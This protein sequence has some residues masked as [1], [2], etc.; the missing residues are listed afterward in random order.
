MN[1]RT[2]ACLALSAA[3]AAAQPAISPEAS[4]QARVP[5]RVSSEQTVGGFAFPESVAYD[6]RAKVLYVSEFGSKLA[7]AEKD[8]MGRISRVSLNGKVLEQ[9]FLPAA[10]GEPLNKPKGIWVRGARLWVTDIDVVWIFDLK[11]KKG[12]KAA[13]PGIQFANDPAVVGNV[14]Y[15]SD[16]RSDQL[17]KV[18]PAD[19]LNS[20]SEPRVTSVFKGASVSP[21]G[22]YPARDGMLLIVGF[23]APD[24]PRGIFA[25]GVSGQIKDLSGPIGRLDGIYELPGGT[26][27]A[28]DWNSGSLFSWTAK[29]G[30][31]KLA[32]GFK[33]PA[34]FCVVPQ[35]AGLTVVVPDLVQSELRF[36]HLK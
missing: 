16:N 34:D 4:A 27:L 36:V 6:P 31:Q 12:R 18:E 22:L 26:L 7:P 5:L 21:N 23:Q 17:F 28:T 9:K 11:T 15:V 2:S 3:L 24:K 8:G 13:L 32:T 10:G 29:G 19:F 33:G 35:G 25:L 30:M 1:K 14:L 20:K